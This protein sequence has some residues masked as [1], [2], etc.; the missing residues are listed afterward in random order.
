MKISVW[1]VLNPFSLL[2]LPLRA[3]FENKKP[4]EA[5]PPPPTPD[6]QLVEQTVRQERV[7]RRSQVS[8]NQT[9]LTGGQ[10][11]GEYTGPGK[12]LLGQ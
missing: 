10:G 9:I 3:A 12:T 5:A 11:A 4:K 1:D 7:R 2:T 8:R 6:D